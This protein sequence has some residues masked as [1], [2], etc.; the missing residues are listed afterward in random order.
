ME[1][2]SEPNITFP[3]L[4]PDEDQGTLMKNRSFGASCKAA[5]KH[6]GDQI[7]SH[8]SQCGKVPR[9]LQVKSFD[10]RDFE[11]R[12]PMGT[13]SFPGRYTFTR[14]D[15]RDSSGG[16]QIGAARVDIKKAWKR[17]YPGDFILK[18]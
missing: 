12:M 3:D 17:D 7:F 18:S 10:T 8:M 5:M 6:F 4:D 1:I 2:L 15:I 14:G 13:C 11:E 9:L 16:N